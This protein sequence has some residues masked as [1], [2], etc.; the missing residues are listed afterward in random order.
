[1]NPNE[2]GDDFVFGLFIGAVM[3]VVETISFIIFFGLAGAL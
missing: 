2:T 3:G 1:M